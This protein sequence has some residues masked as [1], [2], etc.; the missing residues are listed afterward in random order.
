MSLQQRYNDIVK[1]VDHSSFDSANESFIFWILDS[2]ENNDDAEPNF[3]LMY[4]PKQ[5]KLEM[6]QE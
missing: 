5:M 3:W 1:N 4:I 2:L 6:K